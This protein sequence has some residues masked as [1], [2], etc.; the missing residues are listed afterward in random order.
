MW[1]TPR[2]PNCGIAKGRGLNQG[3]G[4]QCLKNYLFSVVWLGPPTV[5]KLTFRNDKNTTALRIRCQQKINCCVCSEVHK[6]VQNARGLHQRWTELCDDPVGYSKEELE[7]TTNELRNSLRS[8]EWDLEDLEETI[9]IL[10]YRPGFRPTCTSW[11]M[12]YV[13]TINFRPCF[14][15]V[16]IFQ[17]SNDSKWKN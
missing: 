1:Q 11:Y 14:V 17:N 5:L 12:F 8:I 2:F 10:Y 3:Q 16:L 7:W 4:E 6:A 13:R 9:N 15:F